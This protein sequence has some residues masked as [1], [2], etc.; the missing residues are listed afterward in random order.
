MSEMPPAAPDGAVIVMYVMPILTLLVTSADSG[1]LV[2]HTVM[3]GSDGTDKPHR[4]SWG[5]IALVIGPLP[6]A[7]VGP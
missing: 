7:G 3:S 1:I 2:M 6:G 5:I 4:A